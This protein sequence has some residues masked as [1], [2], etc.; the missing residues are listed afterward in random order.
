MDNM[1]FKELLEKMRSSL[2]PFNPEYVNRSDYDIVKMGIH[3]NYGYMEGETVRDAIDFF[4][5]RSITAFVLDEQL[6]PLEALGAILLL[7]SAYLRDAA[8]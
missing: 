6:N 3:S 2:T 1:T 8:N 4:E 7:E 5:K